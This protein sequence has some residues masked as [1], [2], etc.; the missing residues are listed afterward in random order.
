MTWFMS[1][2]SHLAFKN[3]THSTCCAFGLDAFFDIRVNKGFSGSTFF[4]V[5]GLKLCMLIF[6][7]GAEHPLNGPSPPMMIFSENL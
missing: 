6:I 2:F 3:F 5:K 1:E 4:S 7:M